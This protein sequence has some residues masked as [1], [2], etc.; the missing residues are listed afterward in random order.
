M[1]T[2][3]K[4]PKG[5]T[6]AEFL[7]LLPAEAEILSACETGQIA[8][9]SNELPK[10]ST[11]ENQVRAAFLR[12]LVLGGDEN[13][14]IHEKGIQIYGAYIF[15]SVNLEN[16]KIPFAID[17]NNCHFN[18]GAV[19]DNIYT[20]N[21][22]SFINCYLCCENLEKSTLSFVYSTIKG[23][24]YIRSCTILGELE[25]QYAQ[26]GTLDCCNSTFQKP[27]EYA[28]SAIGI[29]VNGDVIFRKI[30]C[31]GR[32]CLSGSEINGRLDFE[33]GKF[34]NASKSAITIE[35]AI[36]KSG[37][38]MRAAVTHGE[39]SISSSEITGGFVCNNAIFNNL[40]TYAISAVNLKIRD[41]IH[42]ENA[43]I[44]GTLSLIGAQIDCDINCQGALFENQNGNT[45]IA[46][47]AMI[48]GSIFLRYLKKPLNKASFALVYVK[49]LIDD[50]STWG[51]GIDL[52]GFTYDS[53]AGSSFTDATTRL[54]WLDKQY[55]EYCGLKKD[56]DH[57][58]KPQP[59]RQLQKVLREMGHTEDARQ[60]AI[61]FE[62]RL[63]KAGLIGQAP[64]EWNIFRRF[65]YF[66]LS[67]GFHFLFRMLIGY[68]YRP[69]RLVF[70]MM[71]V[72]LFCAALFWYSALQGVMG[73][74][75]P[76]IFQNPDY[77]ACIPD[78]A[79]AKV[80]I[81]KLKLNQL[82]IKNGLPIAMDQIAIPGAG[83]WYLCAK[84]REEYTGLSP[85]AYSL[86]LILPLVNLQQDSDWAPL[87]PTPESSMW[88]EYTNITLKHITRFFVWFEILFGWLASLLMV[89]VVSGLT[90][91][92]E[93]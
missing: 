87:I 84:L 74:S 83:N 26:L 23:I 64:K 69:I 82:E 58:F 61:A 53:L 16:I 9:V 70:W 56:S 47:R 59:W 12:F 54:T 67:K 93:D 10:K 33:E 14:P 34:K 42:L 78:S 77:A 24:L 57:S 18:N 63:S 80:E 44:I 60:V 36:L 45:F 55:P 62:N 65:I 40:D 75:N 8:G 3:P 30:S 7:P 66:H 31:D 35:S 72:W 17:F 15:E 50:A 11:K 43:T 38:F 48:N 29:V 41:G 27:N 92:R 85:L 89:A 28:I 39:V 32:V 1:I 79:E 2:A 90:K 68:G 49:S 37:F 73:P 22:I 13:T 88:S 71:G 91:R 76:L 21:N 20:E 81:E 6:L 4:K 25:L 86:D 51:N 19:F 52:D 46:D 5:R